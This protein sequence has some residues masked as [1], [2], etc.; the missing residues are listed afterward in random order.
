MPGAKQI[1]YNKIGHI[2]MKIKLNLNEP[3]KQIMMYMIPVK[4][5]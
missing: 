2:K 3:N 1:K 4:W 5:K